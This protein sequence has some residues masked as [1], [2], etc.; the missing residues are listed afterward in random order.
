M[1]AMHDHIAANHPELCP[2]APSKSVMPPDLGAKNVPQ[3]KAPMTMGGVSGVGKG[4]D[5]SANGELAAQNA[6]AFGQ[7]KPP[8]NRKK[9][10]T[11]AGFLSYAQRH[12]L[13]VVPAGEGPVA[14]PQPVPSPDP[15]A[16]KALVAE[17]LTPMTEFYEKQVAEL[18]SQVDKLGAQPDPAMA[19]V[20]GQMARPGATAAAPV[21][22]RSLVDE[23]RER[24]ERASAAERRDFMAYVEMQSRSPDPKV[25]EKALAIIE[26]M[27]A[28][29]PA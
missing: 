12:G 16:I 1:Q 8:K 22:K 4:A 15:A 25:R 6:E 10:V 13:A 28:A 26:K 14:V 19:P 3:P 21:E 18:R 24:A 7:Q 20:R 5:A 2:M 27:E 17:Q 23:A 11:K 9:K 29:V